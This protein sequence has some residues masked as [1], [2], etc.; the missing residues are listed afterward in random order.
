[1]TALHLMI[2]Q[3]R[4]ARFIDHMTATGSSLFLYGAPACSAS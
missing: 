4:R 1:M 2:G 3:M